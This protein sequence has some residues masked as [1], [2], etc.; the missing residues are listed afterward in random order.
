[1]KNKLLLIKV[2]SCWALLDA[3]TNLQAASG[4]WVFQIWRLNFSLPYI[5]SRSWR[6]VAA[7]YYRPKESL[8]SNFSDSSVFLQFL[9]N[10]KL[11]P[12]VNLTYSSNRMRDDK[13]NITLFK[14]IC[15]Q[16]SVFIF[17]KKIR[18][19]IVKKVTLRSRR[20]IKEHLNCNAVAVSHI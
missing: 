15:C 7:T 1:M 13:C 16:I 18:R 6:L 11:C 14:E 4:D 20:Y 8:F 12:C 17:Q 19:N 10:W 9:Q 2:H 3:G 5:C